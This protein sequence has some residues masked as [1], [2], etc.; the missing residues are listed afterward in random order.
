[1]FQGEFKDAVEKITGLKITNKESEYLFKV[2]EPSLT[3]PLLTLPHVQ[4]VD[5]NQDGI[6]D[7]EEELNFHQHRVPEYGIF[8]KEQS[9][10]LLA[11]HNNF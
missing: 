10:V 8:P 9:E 3:S 1:M 4:M 11:G 7:A 5:V 2:D 6:I